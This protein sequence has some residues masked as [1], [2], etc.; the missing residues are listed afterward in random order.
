MTPG[1]AAALGA[2][3]QSSKHSMHSSTSHPIPAHPAPLGSMGLGEGITQ[4]SPAE[5][6]PAAF[7][8]QKRGW[9]V[10]GT[11]PGVTVTPPC[12]LAGFGGFW[13]P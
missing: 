12:Q 2:L 11:K 6:L 10:V 8:G 7:W 13:L 9:Q 4:L 5:Q 1:Q 3:L